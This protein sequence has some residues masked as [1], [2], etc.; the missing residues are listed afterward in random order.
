MGT[1]PLKLNDNKWKVYLQV[2]FKK[3]TK[4]RLYLKPG[5]TAFKDA[6]A[7]MYYNHKYEPDSFRNHFDPQVFWS[8]VCSSKGE[9]EKIEKIMLDFLGEPAKLDFTTS[10]HTEVRDYNHESWMELKDKLYKIQFLNGDKLNEELKIQFPY[11]I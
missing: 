9:A 1:H 11:Y 3:G 4:K 8:K 2:F 7:R 6:D 10:G 5:V